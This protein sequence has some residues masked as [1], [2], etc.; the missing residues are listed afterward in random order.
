[1]SVLILNTV[2]IKY[3]LF[4]VI[5]KNRFVKELSFYLRYVV[6]LCSVF[7]TKPNILV[8]YKKKFLFDMVLIY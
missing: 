5:T 4:V 7:I 3:M 6:T 2:Y 8:K 1:M